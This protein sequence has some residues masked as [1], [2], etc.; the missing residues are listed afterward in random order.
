MTGYTAPQLKLQP[1][2]TD[3][4]RDMRGDVETRK[5][6]HMNETREMARTESL[7]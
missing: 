4:R 6:K 3:Q 1:Q 2:I 5:D 7:R